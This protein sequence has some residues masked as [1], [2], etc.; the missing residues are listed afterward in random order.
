MSRLFLGSVSLGSLQVISQAA[1]R[2]APTFRDYLAID[3]SRFEFSGPLHFVCSIIS[4]RQRLIRCSGS[5]KVPPDAG[6]GRTHREPVYSPTG[7]TKPSACTAYAKSVTILINGRTANAC[8]VADTRQASAALE[9]MRTKGL[10][11]CSIEYFRVSRSK[12]Q[13]GGRVQSWDRVSRNRCPSSPSRNW[14][15]RCL[16]SLR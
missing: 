12:S 15:R 1:C 11:R 9:P 14:H 13:E 4:H 10:A 2:K 7:V 16:E 8:R 5:G 3:A 6:L